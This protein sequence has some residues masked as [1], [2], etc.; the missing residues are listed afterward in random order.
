MGPCAL[1]AS[2]RLWSACLSSGWYA[3]RA[4]SFDDIKFGFHFSRSCSHTERPLF[5]PNPTAS[6]EAGSRE[7]GLGQGAF[8]KAWA[9]RPGW[10][11]GTFA[12]KSFP[13]V[14][15]A[16]SQKPGAL[17]SMLRIGLSAGLF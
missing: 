17:T 13:D 11:G 10:D 9:L 6:G 3:D 8:E 5:R 14:R 4:E 16:T 7:H 1:P 12:V 15:N 2:S